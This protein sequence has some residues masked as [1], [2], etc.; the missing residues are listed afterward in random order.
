MYYTHLLTVVQASKWQCLK[1][2]LGK[3][4]NV[5]ATQQDVHTWINFLFEKSRYFLSDL[6]ERIICFLFHIFGVTEVFLTSPLNFAQEIGPRPAKIYPLAHALR[7]TAVLYLVGYA[8][9]AA[10]SLTAEL[11]NE[12][13][14][15]R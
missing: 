10:C 13:L 15:Y 2:F 3:A 1:T 8:V 11:N 4:Q 6:H 7:L 14:R 9:H 5:V 12:R